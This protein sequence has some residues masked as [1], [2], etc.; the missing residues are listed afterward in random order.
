LKAENKRGHLAHADHQP[1]ANPIYRTQARWSASCSRESLPGPQ[2]QNYG[3]PVFSVVPVVVYSGFLVLFFIGF[4]PGF[5][6]FSSGFC[7]SILF[8]YF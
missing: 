4:F 5:I 2:A 8:S 3:S 6:G 7:F 1:S